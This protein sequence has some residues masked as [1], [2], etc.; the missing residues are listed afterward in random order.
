MEEN[1]YTYKPWIVPYT[2]ILGILQ[3]ASLN[4]AG[5]L[6]IYWWLGL[7][8]DKG[9]QPKWL[10]R[11]HLL[12]VIAGLIGIIIVFTPLR[13]NSIIHLFG[14]EIKNPSIIACLLTIMPIILIYAVPLLGIKKR[15]NFNK[16][17]SPNL[18]TAVAESK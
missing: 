18:D 14:Y 15:K 2:L 12:A 13:E 17:V 4:L 9:F 16:G 8:Y 3:L 7:K 10:Y 11:L 6:W 5:I 1:T